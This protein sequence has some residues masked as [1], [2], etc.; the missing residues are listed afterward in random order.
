M[1]KIPLE[2]SI[3]VVGMGQYKVPTRLTKTLYAGFIPQHGMQI[4]DTEIFFR[5]TTIALAGLQ[6][7][8]HTASPL[9]KNKFVQGD[10]KVTSKLFPG[11][12]QQ[13]R[14]SIEFFTK[15]GWKLER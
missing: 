7:L 14:D 2:L 10:R 1:D 4:L 9:V 3:E 13:F 11:D 8:R 5:V 12:D 15:N 6:S